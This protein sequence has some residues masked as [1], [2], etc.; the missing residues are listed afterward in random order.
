VQTVIVNAATA[1]S[2]LAAAEPFWNIGQAI[3]PLAVLPLSAPELVNR[4]VYSRYDL[5]GDNGFFF[6]WLNEGNE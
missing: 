1:K 4:P 6:Y 5:R 3:T 2:A